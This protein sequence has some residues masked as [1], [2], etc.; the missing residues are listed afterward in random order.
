MVERV[1]VSSPC[2]ECPLVVTGVALNMRVLWSAAERNIMTR[3]S[4]ESSEGPCLHHDCRAGVALNM[5][6]SRVLWSAAERK[7]MNRNSSDSNEGPC[8]HHDDRAG[9]EAQN[10]ISIIKSE[11]AALQGRMISAA[12]S[13]FL[14]WTFAGGR[15]TGSI[16]T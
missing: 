16:V 1:N 3:N 11:A 2:I 8:L 4:T 10:T 13:D 6:V 9:P 15:S 14:P 7:M 12:A 5:R